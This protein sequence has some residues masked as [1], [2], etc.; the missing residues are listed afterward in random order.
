MGEI[1]GIG[2]THYPPLCW[3]DEN[4][5]DLLRMLLRAPGVPAAGKERAR[6]PGAMSAEL[7]D[8]DG[9]A[10]AKRHRERLVAGFRRCRREIDEFRPDFVVVFGDD[11]YE[12]FREDLI[13]PF[14]VFGLDEIR[15]RPWASGAGA[16]RPNRWGEPADL[17]YVVCGHREGARAIARGLIEKGIDLPY[18]YRSLHQDGLAHAFTNTLLY[19][20]WDRGGFPHPIV[21]FHVN[22]YGASLLSTRGGFSHL[23]SSSE[24]RGAAEP[25]RPA[26]PPAPSPRRCMEV[27]A[28]LAETLLETRWR[29]ALVASSSWSHA[30]LTPRGG[31]LWPDL[32]ADRLLVEALRRGD[33]AAWRD[34]PLEE[35]EA[36]GQHEIL[37]W[38]VLAGAMERLGRAPEIVDWIETFVFNSNKC[39]AIF[40][41]KSGATP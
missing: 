31:Y 37:N 4:M 22:C 36:A 18:A 23:V 12:N 2:L 19:L 16:M 28:R 15:L 8:D 10:A 35:Y 7:A 3:P 38:C 29:V 33:Y 41:P 14:C 39:F 5:A 32:D 13:P 40:P 25:A 20:D 21:P 6:W 9:L 34:R 17:T 24:P 30:F 26:D 1:L 11:Q 27:G